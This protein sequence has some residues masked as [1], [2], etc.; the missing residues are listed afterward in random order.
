[1]K[2]KFWILIG[3]LVIASMALAACQPAAPEAPAEEAA[4]A[5]EE[6]MPEEEEAMPEEEE[7][8][9]EATPTSQFMSMGDMQYQ[10]ELTETE[11]SNPEAPLWEQMLD[12]E[13]KGFVDTSGFMK[14]PPYHVCFSNASIANS[15]RVVGNAAMEYEVS[16]HPEIEE[17]TVTDAQE[18]PEKQI[19]DIEDLLTK[20][21]DVLIVS[22][23]TTE[24]LTPA[25]EK[26]VATG[27]P[28]VVFDRGVNT[29]PTTF[30]HP[31]GGFAFGYQGASWLVDAMGGEGN[32]IAIRIL[33][34]VDVLETRWL[35]ANEV[36]ADNPGI[37]VVGV[38]FGEGDPGKVKGIVLD[39]LER[40]GGEIDGFW[41]DY[42]GVTKGAYEAFV[43]YG[44]DVPP[45]TAED[46]NGWLKV[47]DE[48]G[49]ESIS[50]NY[51]TYQWRTPVI[52]ALM[53]L[54]GEEVPV[55]WILPQPVI[56]QDNLSEFVRQDLPDG[57]FAMNGMPDEVVTELWAGTE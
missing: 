37:E 20:D 53:I 14:E 15:W 22:P 40:T 46:F 47:W 9:P 36:F 50:P 10:L 19:S 56:T 8:A 41:T 2:N 26:A 16:L 25:V 51:P 44:A 13:N 35:A 21:C 7:A 24:A 39:Y 55:E 33:P 5:E 45:M 30:I 6:A 48:E 23:A 17:F 52:A 31:I 28:V 43:D 54:N 27:I 29:T 1:M 18:N 57:H 34:G 4:P 38:E 49:L 3:L 42:G 11:P 12:P 32:V